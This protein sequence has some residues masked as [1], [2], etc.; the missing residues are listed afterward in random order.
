MSDTERRAAADND[1]FATSTTELKR[2]AQ[3]LML[4]RSS[5]RSDGL[6]NEILADTALDILLALYAR[7]ADRGLVEV[8]DVIGATP[9]PSV[10]STR[11]LTALADMGLVELIAE[12]AR[13]RVRL[14]ATGKTKLGT[15]LS[16]VIEQHRRLMEDDQRTVEI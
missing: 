4:A 9:S 2:A 13:Q 15:S 14:T 10:V 7:S 5:L 3:A 16:I 11:W 12:G 8:S 1:Q 6:P